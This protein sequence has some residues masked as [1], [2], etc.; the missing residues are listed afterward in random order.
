[1]GAY[2]EQPKRS[3]SILIDTIIPLKVRRCPR[4]TVV[5]RVVRS[6]APTAS[7][8][9]FS[10]DLEIELIGVTVMLAYA[11]K[12][13]HERIVGVRLIQLLLSNEE[14]KD[15]FVL[16]SSAQPCLYI[17]SAF[18]TGALWERKILCVLLAY[19]P[20]TFRAVH[21]GGPCNADVAKGHG[22]PLQH[23]P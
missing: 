20:V 19:R 21:R 11:G 8:S 22:N 6:L 9:F 10:I 3:L 1:M 12:I 5:L 14:L 16:P 13:F 18:Q 15:L 2:D 7:I 4:P 23:V 17:G